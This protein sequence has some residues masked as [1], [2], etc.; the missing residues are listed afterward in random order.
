V[1]ALRELQW[2]NTDRKDFDRFKASLT[3]N[4]LPLLDALGVNYRKLD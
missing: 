1:L 2:C 4:A 3:A